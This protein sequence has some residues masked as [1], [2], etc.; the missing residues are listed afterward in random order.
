[1]H[2]QYQKPIRVS[3]DP[4]ISQ[5]L[6]KHPEIDMVTS[7]G[8]MA[9]LFSCFP[10][11]Y[12]QWEIPVVSKASTSEKRKRVFFLE[13]PYVPKTVTNR[14]ATSLYYR[15]VFKEIATKSSPQ[16]LL[17][18]NPEQLDLSSLEPSSPATAY[19]IWTLNELHILVR[20]KFQ[21]KLPSDDESSYQVI[22]LFSKVHFSMKS[23][24]GE[25][26]I[27]LC[28]QARWYL[29]AQMRPNGKIVVAH[30]DP[31]DSSIFRMSIHELS[32]LV[33]SGFT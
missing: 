1:M 21:C 23:L 28:E 17:E 5:I 6:K 27:T 25:E 19:T 7:A 9:Q 13:K 32:I 22:G 33:P 8:I 31:F 10:P 18:N 15:K 14:Q 30:V 2:L 4:I 29:H 11:T 3:E 26:D 12:D 24:K 20:G 16:F